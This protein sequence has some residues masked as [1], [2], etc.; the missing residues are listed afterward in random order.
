MRS[1]PAPTTARSPQHAVYPDRRYGS[2]GCGAPKIRDGSRSGSHLLG[3]VTRPAFNR[4]PT[5][6][7]RLSWSGWPAD[8]MTVLAL[9]RPQARFLNTR[10]TVH[11]RSR[12]VRYRSSRGTSLAR[13]T[14]MSMSL[15][16]VERDAWRMH[17]GQLLPPGG[18]LANKPH[19]Y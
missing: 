15:R 8:R 3:V 2:G 10:P 18:A 4:T 16:G 12:L 9:C 13:M 19:V 5:K 11:R 14:R 7:R 6:P 17:T 1:T